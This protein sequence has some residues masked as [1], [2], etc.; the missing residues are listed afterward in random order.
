MEVNIETPKKNVA[1]G[2]LV[3]PARAFTESERGKL[4]SELESTTGLKIYTR[5]LRGSEKAVVFLGRKKD[6]NYLGLLVE[7]DQNTPAQLGKLNETTVANRVCKLGLFPADATRASWLREALP[8]LRPRPLGLQKSVG[9]GDR[10]GLA[11][12]GHIQALRSFGNKDS[13]A[14]M[15]PIFAQQ[16]MREN[17][18]TGRTPQSVMD[19]ALWGVFQEGWEQGYGADADHLKTR[20]DVDVCVEAG[21]TFYTIDPG[22]YVDN[23][24]STASASDL[25]EKLRTLPWEFLESSP[26]RIAEQLSTKP[27]DLVGRTKQLSRESVLRAAA[28]Y[29]R[30]VA[31]TVE[32]YRHLEKRATQKGLQFE[33]E[34]SVDETDTVTTL[35]E[36]IYIAHE[37]QRLGVKWVSLAP[38]YFGR[39]E[40][41]VDFLEEPPLSLEET[42]DKFEETFALHVAVSRTYGPYK[43][44]LHSGSD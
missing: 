32:L 27:I 38:R 8:F 43:L 37:L 15:Q 16:S 29:G 35:A 19:D 1:L 42:L 23:S 18:R 30:A 31:H 20:E 17:A 34:M 39:F 10:L 36:H 28:K 7:S 41:G 9:F 14:P 21:Y 40:K 2:R 12:P 11:T 13:D 25:E 26:N 4:A 24:A 3:E 6:M 22:E 33:L 44:S 5:S